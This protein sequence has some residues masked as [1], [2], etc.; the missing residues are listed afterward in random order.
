MFADS[1]QEI[2]PFEV[3]NAKLDDLP[4]AEYIKQVISSTG[5]DIKGCYNVFVKANNFK[6]YRFPNN[7]LKMVTDVKYDQVCDRDG[8]LKNS[9]FE[10]TNLHIFEDMSCK[11]TDFCRIKLKTENMDCE[12]TVL[13]P[14]QHGTQFLWFVQKY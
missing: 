11:K 9:T 10:C 8:F 12:R 7:D 13:K 2:E 6:L 4:N 14:W 3:K 5:F 1:K